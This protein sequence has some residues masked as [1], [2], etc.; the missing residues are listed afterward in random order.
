LEEQADARS[1]RGEVP[2]ESTIVQVSTASDNWR[3]TVDGRP[4][5]HDIAYGWADAFRVETGGTAELAYR[6]PPAPQAA[7]VAQAVLWVLALGVA[8]RM[9][10]G[11]GEPLPTTA[12]R[13]AARPS[14]EPALGAD[15]PAASSENGGTGDAAETPAAPDTE[16]AAEPQPD[17][18][19]REAKPVPAARP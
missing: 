17:P 5:D 1:A 11:A 16:P 18:P 9:R 10:F 14:R 2:D 6:T 3:L 19:D 13:R 8:L 4:V 7:V 15:G 12:P